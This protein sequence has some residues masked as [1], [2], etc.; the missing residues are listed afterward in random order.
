VIFKHEFTCLKSTNLIQL[1]NIGLFIRFLH[2][3]GG[4]CKW[5]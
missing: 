3:W 2:L 1:K 5:T 4:R